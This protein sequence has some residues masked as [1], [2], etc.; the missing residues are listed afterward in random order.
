VIEQRGIF[1]QQLPLMAKP[2]GTG[3]EKIIYSLIWP[4]LGKK[5]CGFEAIIRYSLRTTLIFF[6]TWPSA[7]LKYFA[8]QEVLSQKGLPQ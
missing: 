6:N 7:L 1:S 2:F 8:F 4:R 5:D 3:R